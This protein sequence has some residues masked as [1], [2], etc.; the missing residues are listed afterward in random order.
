MV[1]LA[2]YV[3][4][5][6]FAMGMVSAYQDDILA[7]L[8]SRL[9]FDVDAR[10]VSGDWH[11]FTPELVLTELR[12]SFPDS[13]DSPLELGEGRLSIDVLSSLKTRS[14]QSS[15]LRLENLTLHAFVDEFGAWDVAGF[16]SDGSGSLNAWLEAFIGNVTQVELVGNS[17]IVGLP[18]R[19]ERSFTLDLLLRREG[20]RRQLGATLTASE[21]AIVEVLV[22][23]LGDPFNRADYDGDIYIHTQVRELASFVDLMPASVQSDLLVSGQAE[24]E[25]WVGW[26]G[27]SSSIDVQVD[28][29]ALDIRARDNSWRVPVQALS[30]G[31]SFVEQRNLWSVFV[32][33]AS[34]VRWV[35]RFV[36]CAGTEAGP[37]GGESTVDRQRDHARGPLQCAGDTVAARGAGND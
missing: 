11:M 18:D 4:V 36:A 5:G 33:P 31:G 7:Q 27:G 16:E 3:S 21:G 23:G 22:D 12:L 6:R 14:L 19:S 8:N 10:S 32:G 34:T 9:P 30:F 26:K 17:L 13:P 1:M 35:G 37:C 28:A 24:L 29:D 15:A 20:A 2:I 25:A